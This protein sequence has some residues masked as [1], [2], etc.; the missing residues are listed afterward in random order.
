[1]SKAWSGMRR[2]GGEIPSEPELARLKAGISRPQTDVPARHRDIA[3]RSAILGR[4]LGQDFREPD[5]KI[6]RNGDH[7][8]PGEHLPVH[9]HVHGV[10]GDL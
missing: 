7:F 4:D 3:G 10:T 8:A 6:L 5:A 1:M 2:L 9:Q